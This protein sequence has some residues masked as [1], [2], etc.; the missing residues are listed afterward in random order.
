MAVG[1][2]PRSIFA[3]FVSV[4]WWSREDKGLNLKQPVGSMDEPWLIKERPANPSFPSLPSRSWEVSQP[5]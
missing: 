3:I 5:G 2:P 1:K 4:R